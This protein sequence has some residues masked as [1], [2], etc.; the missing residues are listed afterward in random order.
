MVSSPAIC[1]FIHF[2]WLPDQDST[3]AGV[4]EGGYWPSPH[5]SLVFAFQPLFTFCCK[6]VEHMRMVACVVCHLLKLFSREHVWLLP[7]AAAYMHN[8]L[9]YNLYRWMCCLNCVCV[10]HNV[11]LSEDM[12]IAYFLHIFKEQGNPLKTCGWFQHHLPFAEVFLP[13]TEIHV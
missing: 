4:L 8:D 6:L 13:R 3:S 5:A 10:N 7:S 12:E 11:G 1:P 9:H 2:P